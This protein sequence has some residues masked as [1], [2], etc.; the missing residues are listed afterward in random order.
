MLAKYF[1]RIKENKIIQALVLV[2][3]A[4]VAYEVRFVLIAIFLAFIISSALLPVFNYLRSKNFPNALALLLP[5]IILLLIIAVTLY[6][7]LPNV[8]DQTMSFAE[9]LPHYAGMFGDKLDTVLKG[10]GLG[11]S[12]E[13]NAGSIVIS[14]TK[15][16]ASIVNQ[17]MTIIVFVIVIIVLSIHALAGSE[18]IKESFAR[19]FGEY[20]KAKV[21][22]MITDIESVMG[23]W[24][25]GQI[26]VCTIIGFLMGISLW[27]AGVPY[28]LILG[29]L[30]GVLEFV[31]IIGILI[32]GLTSILVGLSVSWSLA[33]TVLII[34]FIVN[35]LENNVVVPFVM[36]RSV[37]IRP[38]T[39]MIAVLIGV[40][41]MGIIG[42]FLA[43][44]VVCILQ[45]VNR[46]LTV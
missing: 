11:S 39:T 16:F 18:R 22:N 10:T 46:H 33:G 28:A 40:Q 4:W 27:I 24:A 5:Y 35:F 30:T 26:I 32:S 15:N 3:F 43:V 6:Y 37:K 41:L 42:A 14:I 17:I 31:P 8:Y 9:N 36:S 34:F 1:S 7:F 29:I 45:I 12:F 23:K 2:F 38:T 13:G 19:I 44:P 21:V 20:H 25:R